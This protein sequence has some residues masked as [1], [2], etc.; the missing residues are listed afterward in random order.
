MFQERKIPQAR[1]RKWKNDFGIAGSGPIAETQYRSPQSEQPGEVQ[2]VS[3]RV[4]RVY[5]DDWV[6]VRFVQDNYHFG[7]EGYW[8]VRGGI[9][10]P[11]YLQRVVQCYKH[12]QGVSR[13]FVYAKRLPEQVLEQLDQMAAQHPSQLPEVFQK[14]RNSGFLPELSKLTASSC[15]KTLDWATLKNHYQDFKEKT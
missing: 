14:L 4:V 7:K 10:W 2:L 8:M 5:Q 11:R 6:C 13:D 9:Q 1:S 3:V 12:N 15:P